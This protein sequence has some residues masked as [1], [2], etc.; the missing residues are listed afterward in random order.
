MD[1][2]GRPPSQAQQPETLALAVA[3]VLVQV[4]CLTVVILLAALGGGLLL[5]SQFNSRPLFTLLLVLGS[6][7][8]TVYLLFR[9]V[10]SG[11]NRMQ[12]GNRPRKE[13]DDGGHEEEAS[14]EN[15]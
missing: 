4:G 2:A 10:L 5:D 9:I 14:G 6:V 3:G 7:P 8:I 11:M 12:Q 1:E 15:P 13:K